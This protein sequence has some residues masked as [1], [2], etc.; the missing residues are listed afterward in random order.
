MVVDLLE[1][2]SP[3]RF[4]LIFA[5]SMIAPELDKPE[6]TVGEYYTPENKS[7]KISYPQ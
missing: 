2:E 5:T 1:K 3:N 4:Q 7:L 6:Y